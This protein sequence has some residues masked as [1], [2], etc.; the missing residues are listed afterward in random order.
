[1]RRR[2]FSRSRRAQT[3]NTLLQP[4]ADYNGFLRAY[5]GQDGITLQSQNLS[6]QTCQLQVL[7]LYNGQTSTSVL[8]PGQVF[9]HSFPLKAA[10]G[11]YDLVLSFDSDPTF[12]QQFAG[13]LETGKVSR[14]DPGASSFAGVK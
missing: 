2:R 8:A 4:H 13:H 12:R 9:R 14:T 10:F 6:S 7:N 11:W 3:A 1:M 5:I